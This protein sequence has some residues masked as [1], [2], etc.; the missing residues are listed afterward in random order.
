MASEFLKIRG[1][2]E[3]NLKNI[4]LDLPK[5]KLIVF[6]GVSGSGKSS[7]AIDTIYAEGQRRYVESLSAYAR[8]FLGIM[9]KPDIDSIEGLSPAIAITQKTT[10]HNPRS[11]VGTVTEIYDYLRLL[12][13]RI[14]HPHCPKCGQE[15]QQQSI[16]QISDQVLLNLQDNGQKQLRL[17]ILSPVVRDKRGEFS[18]LF[19]QLNRQGFRRVR[20]DGNWHPLDL[21]L[22]IIKTNR[23]DI[24]V[25]IDQLVTNRSDLEKEDKRREFLKRLSES[26]EMASVLSQGNI[27]T[28]QVFDKGFDFPE[29]PQDLLETLYSEEFACPSCKINLPEIEPRTFSFNSPHGACPTCHGLG[30]Q[31]KIDPDLVINPNLSILEGGIYPWSAIGDGNTWLKRILQAVGDENEVNLNQPLG[32]LPS[33]KLKVILYG[34]GQKKYLI[35]YRNELDGENVHSVRYEGVVN[36]LERRYRETDSD[37]MRQDIEKYMMQEP[38]PT[39]NG[40]RLKPEALA[41][42]IGG[43]NIYQVSLLS[44]VEFDWW[45]SLINNV[46]SSKEQEISTI[47]VKEIRTRLKFLLS[48]GIGYITIARNS[49]SLAGG[50]AQR[51]RLA[52]QIGSGLTGVLYVLDEPSIGLH[53]RDQDR[54]VQTLKNLRDLGNTVIVVEHD[55]QTMEESDWLVD[56]GPGAGE[57]GGEVVSQG[58]PEQVSHDRHSITGQYLSGRKKVGHIADQT[59]SDGVGEEE[60]IAP[61]EGEL[62]ILGCRGHNLKN[63]DVTLPLG[64]LIC[65]TGVSGSGK[66]TLV[67][68]TLYQALRQELGQKMERKPQS[69]SGMLGASKIRK[70]ININQSPIGRTPRSNPATYTKAF[71]YIRK[72]FSMTREAKLHGY[73]PGRFSFNVKGGRCEVCKGEGQIKIEMQFLSDVY[74]NCDACEGKRYNREALDIEYK[75]KNISQV[76]DMTIDEALLF[77]D[78]IPALRARLQTLQDVGLGYIRLGQPAPTLSGGEAQRVKLASELAKKTSVETLYLLDEPTTGLHFADLE[79]LILVLKKLVAKGATVLVIEHNLDVIANADWIIDLG[80]EGG[81][82]GGQVVATGTVTNLCQSAASHTGM[83]LKKHL[84]AKTSQS[85]K[86]G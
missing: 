14:G 3:H 63:I 47:I 77:F 29:Q 78:R 25:V 37:S 55:Q 18:K 75:G 16:Q 53:Q 19:L 84:A 26:L 20:I 42:T 43:K 44:V 62:S 59:L 68:E 40:A 76:L 46:L 39:C 17:M 69:Y 85:S 6:T 30:T 11:T 38:C 12:Y 5:N 72:L 50:E 48:V 2:R 8:Q 49:S 86:R 45:L 15:I 54:L 67:N 1:A 66:S 51:I 22:A 74:V 31:L 21:G 71:D 27:V 60:K 81:E 56:F 32:E 52:S 24:D 7:L 70:V 65:V 10:S 82:E 73:T 9:N 64:N 41:V 61:T 57:M 35:K 13:A 23:H 28:A 36:N 80:P 33:E 83:Y 34:T 4:D 79:R 58:T